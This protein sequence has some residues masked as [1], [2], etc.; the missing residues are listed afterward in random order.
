MAFLL[1]LGLAG[2]TSCSRDSRRTGEPAA[3]QAGR[4]AY[5]ASR[6]IKREAKEAAKE[7]RQAGKEFT[8]G[9]K[10]AK[11]SDPPRRD[12]PRPQPKK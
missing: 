10:E 6:E 1:A 12:E 8:Q 11:H 4:D 7:I 2:L 9:W 3:R 5:H